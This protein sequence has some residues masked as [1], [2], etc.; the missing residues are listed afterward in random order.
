MLKKL[1]IDYLHSFDCCNHK[2][3][4]KDGRQQHYIDYS[5][6]FILK[7]PEINNYLLVDKLGSYN[8]MYFKAKSFFTDNELR[9]YTFNYKFKTLN[10]FFIN[11]DILL[12]DFAMLSLLIQNNLPINKYKK[13]FIFDC[14]ELTVYFRNVKIPNGISRNILNR[15]IIKDFLDMN[16]N[17]LVFLVTPYNFNDVNGFNYIEYYKK[18]NFNLFKDEL[19]KK[20]YNDELIYYYSCNNEEFD[21]H[22]LIKLYSK[23]D[24]LVITKKYSDLFYYKNVLYTAKP[25]VGFIEQFGRMIFEM[26]YFGCNVI[27]DQSYQVEDI[28]GLDYYLDYG[29]SLDILDDNI[30]EIINENI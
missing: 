22:F 14:L 13:I 29:G 24:N 30:M 6:H 19:C 7:Y 28:T 23:Y 25:Y 16:T 8:E 10:N 1:S 27:L 12:C 3:I 11:S 18:I 5:Q 20:Q 2:L 17:K 15:K 4:S 9:N 21:D 26:R